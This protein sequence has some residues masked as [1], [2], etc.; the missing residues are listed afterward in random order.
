MRERLFTLHTYVIAFANTELTHDRNVDD[1]IGNSCE[2]K[3]HYSADSP[4]PSSGTETMSDVAK[5]DP[6]S[7]PIRW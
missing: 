3:L 7:M 6:A 2:L 5:M 1:V 4:V